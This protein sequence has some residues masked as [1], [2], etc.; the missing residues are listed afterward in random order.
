M[1]GVVI[2]GIGTDVGKTVV[3]AVVC[4]AL[5]AD[6]WKPVQSGIADGPGDS[7]TVAALLQCG[8]ERV[9]PP[10]YAFKA[11]L[12]P[13]AAAALE[14]SSVTLER[15]VAP[16]TNSPLVVELAGGVLV[17]LN[18][19]HTNIDLVARLGLPVLVVSRHYL[20]SINHTLLTLEAL[21]AREIA[22]MGV[23]FNGEELP[24][25]E[26]VIARLGQVPVLGRI[27]TFPELTAASIRAAAESLDL[28]RV[29]HEASLHEL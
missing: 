20:G 26:R 11:P 2:A 5:S 13:H 25:T 18:D 7:Q 29:I 15:L 12:S 24:D 9:H 23:I 22:V 14:G 21:R 8:P 3:S 10:A 19:E 4:E 17:P 28:A 27:P 6:Y 16:N 1:K